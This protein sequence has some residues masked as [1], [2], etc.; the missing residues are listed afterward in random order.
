MNG[1]QVGQRGVEWDSYRRR[2]EET[3]ARGL[4][5][6]DIVA[7]AVLDEVEGRSERQDRQTRG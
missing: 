5:R 4:Y 6:I 3:V 2:K 7:A 1:S